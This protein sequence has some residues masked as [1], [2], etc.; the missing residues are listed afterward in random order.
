M[1]RFMEP[2]QRDEDLSDKPASDFAELL[3]G[4]ARH[5]KIDGR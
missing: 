5:A 3:L 1:V 4:Q 2:Q